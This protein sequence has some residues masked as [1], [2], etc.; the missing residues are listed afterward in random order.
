VETS[1]SGRRLTDRYQAFWER[2]DR[3]GWRKFAL[4]MGA[5]ALAFLLAVYS[6]VFVQQGDV[7]ATGICASLALLLSGYVAFTAVPYLARRTRLEWLR[8]GMD[9]KLTRVGAYF[10]ALILLLAIAGLN[11]GNNLLYLILSSLLAAILMSGVL[12]L[13]V[14]TGVGLEILLPDHVFARRPVP[15]RVH[16]QNQKRFIP[17]F[18]ITLTGSG[19]IEQEARQLKRKSKALRFILGRS[20][21]LALLTAGIA[22]FATLALW[23]LASRFFGLSVSIVVMLFLAFLLI[24]LLVAVAGLS[25]YSRTKWGKEEVGPSPEEPASNRA[26]RRILRHPLYFPFLPGGRAIARTVELEFQRRGLYREDG[27]ALSTRFPFGFLEKTMRLPVTRDLW[28]YPAVE[29]TE[30]FYEILPMLSGELEAF[31]K[32]RGHD[33]YS[34]RE[35][36][37]T[38]SARHVDWKASAR[39]RSFKVREFAREDERR[40][41]L[42]LDPRIG[43]ADPK[44]LARF[45]AAVEFCACLAWHFYEVDAQMEFC[46]GDFQIQSARAGEIIYDI[47]RHLAAVAPS[48]EPPGP[49]ALGGPEE[50][51]FRIICTA[52]PRGSVP[53]TLW[54]R[55]YFIFFDTLTP[56]PAL[57]DQRP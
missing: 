7:L 6:S 45:E 18:S 13:A 10:I 43:P 14:L 54:S 48:F 30:E 4:A 15:A 2:V 19:S 8:A 11:T 27:F 42:M 20:F 28:V 44:M 40:L 49:P 47:L 25:L 51:V 41:Q 57:T 12:S 29:P 55:S 33:L 9:Y 22:V 17:S 35:M 34:I 5:L 39:T 32:G 3:P 53:T 23:G 37:P 36:L 56:S 46:C 26:N 24:A 1:L 50:N 31:Q 52:L 21:K 38:D 16:L